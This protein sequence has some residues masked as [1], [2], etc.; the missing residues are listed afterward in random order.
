MTAADFRVFVSFVLSGDA[1]C[2]PSRTKQDWKS[3]RVNVQLLRMGLEQEG[4]TAAGSGLRPNEEERETQEKFTDGLN[5]WTWLLLT[6]RIS[7]HIVVSPF[8]L[9]STAVTSHRVKH[10]AGRMWREASDRLT[11][12]EFDDRLDRIRQT[13]GDEEEAPAAT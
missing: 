12:G 5:V 9:E 1:L 13:A 11:S 8:V 4:A 2:R 3:G 7:F 10:T 6:L